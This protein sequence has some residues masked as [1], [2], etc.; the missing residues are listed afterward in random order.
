M[1]DSI[2]KVHALLSIGH[3]FRDSAQHFEHR[4]RLFRDNA[5]ALDGVARADVVI[6]KTIEG[7]LPRLLE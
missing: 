1:G 5:R 6:G 3:P 2:R 7:P 4:T